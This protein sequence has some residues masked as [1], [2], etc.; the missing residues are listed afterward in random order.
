LA[1]CFFYAV[2]FYKHKLFIEIIKHNTPLFV[3]N[4]I[5]YKKVRNMKDQ[6]KIIAALLVGAAAGAALSLLL[7][8]SSGSELRDDIADYVNDLVDKSKNKAQETANNVR[9]YGNDMVERAKSRVNDMVNNVSG[10]KDRI[11][12]EVKSAVNGYADNAHDYAEE[13]VNE[14]KSKI[15][16]TSNDVNNAVQGI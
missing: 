11:S 3:N 7:A 15:K 2:L 8:P 14:A 6:T 9:S 12:G 1:G 13:T 16:N 10:Y 4:L 5:I